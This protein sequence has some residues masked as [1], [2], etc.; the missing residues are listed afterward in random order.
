MN[1]LE[2]RLSVAGP[3]TPTERL[4]HSIERMIHWAD[5]ERR[6]RR[7]LRNPVLTAAIGCMVGLVIGGSAGFWVE[8]VAT[9]LSGEATTVIVIE[10]TPELERWLT[11]DDLRSRP[12]FFER[13][14][15]DLETVYFSGESR[16]TTSGSS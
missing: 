15:G 3:A 10:P 12:G 14:H 7:G 1:E 9:P 13:Q 8:G 2:E 6:S 16:P 11:G 5:L 4:D